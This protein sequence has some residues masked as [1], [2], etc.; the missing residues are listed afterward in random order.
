MYRGFVFKFRTVAHFCSFT[1]E[2]RNKQLVDI[3]GGNVDF[4]FKKLEKEAG[5]G[6][7]VVSKSFYEEYHTDLESEGF[8]FT[9]FTAQDRETQLYLLVLPVLPKEATLSVPETKPLLDQMNERKMD[10]QKIKTLG[11][12]YP[13]MN[14][15]DQFV[16]LRLTTKR[17]FSE[18]DIPEEADILSFQQEREKVQAKG[19]EVLECDAVYNGHPRLLIKGIPGVGK[20]TILK[21]FCFKAFEEG[22]YP[23]FI[24]CVTLPNIQSWHYPYVSEENIERFMLHLIAFAFLY[25]NK[26]YDELNSN[27]QKG[28]AKITEVVEG[29]A[30]K[31]EAIFCLD[32]LDEVTDPLQR[33][34]ILRL[35]SLWL[36]SGAKYHIYLAARDHTFAG[37]SED[38][39]L[40]SVTPFAIDQ[41][42]DL[43]RKF[44]RENKRLL[45]RFNKESV[46][47]QEIVISVA[48]TPLLAILVLA[49]FERRGEFA[50]KST[51]LRFIT[52]FILLRIW[53]RLKD[54]KFQKSIDEI[55]EITLDPKAIE[56]DRDVS[57]LIDALEELAWNTVMAYQSGFVS[58]FKDEKIINVLDNLFINKHPNLPSGI[59]S[60]TLLKGM[61]DAYF[62]LKIAHSPDYYTFTHLSVLEFLAAKRMS[63][64][65]NG[66]F[67]HAFFEFM[68]K[69]EL[70][71]L[72][73]LPL[74]SALSYENLERAITGLNRCDLGLNLLLGDGMAFRI[75]VEAEGFIR[76]QTDNY[77]DRLIIQE[78]KALLDDF[79][80]LKKKFLLR[81]A[82]YLKE[83]DSNKL[84]EY[85]KLF[86][87]TSRFEDKELLSCLDYG[88]FEVEAELVKARDTLLEQMV[89]YRI[90]EEWKT[91]QRNLRRESKEEAIPSLPEISGVEGDVL[92]LDSEGYDPEDK[93][94]NYYRKLI[95]PELE[96]FLGSP[97]LKHSSLVNNAV[98]S[99]D[100]RYILSASDDCTLKLWDKET[101]KEIRTFK[102]HSRAVNSC[103]FSSDG[104][105][106]LSA[107]DD[108]TLK[109][110]D[111]ETGKEIR[112]FKGHSG[113]VNSCVFSSDGKYILSASRDYTLK[114][115]DKEKGGEIRT[116]KGHSGAVN[117][118]VFSSDG[119]YILS[120][121]DDCTLKLWDKEKGGE[122]RTF[123]GHSGAVNSCVFSSD[124]KYIL[125]A[126][127]DRTLKLWDKEKG[128]EI[129]TFKG[130]SGAVNSCV[131][132]SDGK[133]ILSASNDRTLKLWDKEKGGEI[134]TFK[135]HSGA[136]NS[137]V[138]SSDGKYILS[139]SNDRTLK[140]WDKEKGGE[141]RTF[142][143]HSGAVNSCVFSSDGKYILSASWDNTLKLWDKE[144]GGEIRTFKGHSGA[145]NSCVFSSDG[146]Y[147]LSASW[148]NTLKLWD[149][150]KGGEIRTFK[151]H[152]GAV[153]SCV[154]SKDDRYILSASDDC[155]LKL[156]DKEK[157]GEIRTFK[158][159]SDWVNS[160]VFSSDGKYILSASNDRTLKLWDKEK[161]GEIRTF[162]GHSGAVNSCVFSSDGKYILSASWDNTL[163]LWDKEKGGEI[164]TFKGHSRAV[165]SCVFSSDGKYILSASWDNTL[166]LW[167]VKTGRC[168]KSINLP[169]RACKIA[170]HPIK[171]ETVL[172]ANLNG[173]LSIFELEEL[174]E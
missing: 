25:Q 126:S 166:K 106:I 1:A 155:T 129:R 60:H 35:V 93:N 57:L 149:K 144:K 85:S 136:V 64:L 82:E 110:W 42:Q 76:E 114:L 17:W 174:L 139:A 116:F 13:D 98:F 55:F 28:F 127:N 147:I 32:A 170:I 38:I 71:P 31:G 142:K 123:K 10:V 102:G 34:D 44:F 75:L 16:R 84:R 70:F 73:V 72:D 5:A 161:G 158:G 14:M 157:G 81:F 29:W 53:D 171:K 143:G 6:Q 152:S 91:D 51:M 151:G 21:Y 165:N 107:S 23:L 122:I 125:S 9:P 8:G 66:E 168:I 19:E 162:K 131:F 43:G 48:T 39:P 69:E 100:D 83:N 46:R 27:E 167:E 89:N 50:R 109:L 145:V 118:C 154:F 37:L 77:Q 163:K 95:G 41:F 99:P 36:K 140:L 112:T 86:N 103:V 33:K 68:S 115:W 65:R 61:T 90:V 128:G 92:R 96:G 49:W 111:K 59:T 88:L 169:W 104:K 121:S 63:I 164:R 79:G 54:P 172:T 15:K 80:A 105:Y 22:K 58:R 134:R 20:T 7:M 87:A 119:K 97:N 108:C 160:C 135:G 3:K 113:A 137:C 150:E 94:F 62:L 12:V 146:K 47:Q 45:E 117:S 132:S 67:L 153:N 124:G 173:T 159:H 56:R 2:Y 24:P 4:L 11:G 26:T 101:G 130:H 74:F 18:K 141:I 138:F 156:W 30:R 52:A 148:D 78:H 133:Y 40:A 120:A